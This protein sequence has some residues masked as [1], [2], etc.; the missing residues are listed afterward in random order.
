METRI[1][2]STYD[3][4]MIQDVPR[5]LL[6]PGSVWSMTDF[7]PDIDGAPIQKRGGWQAGG[8]FSG[9][10][11]LNAIAYSPFAGGDIYCAIDDRGHLWRSPTETFEAAVLAKSPSMYWRLGSGVG[12]TTATDSSG[13]G[14][15]GACTAVT[16]GQTGAVTG[17]PD[18]AALFGATSRVQAGTYVPFVSGS[19]RTFMG[20]FKRT[21]TA[22]RDALFSGA[23][24]SPTDDH[25]GAELF[26]NAGGSDV[27]FVAK[28][29]TA[30]GTWTAAWPL[31]GVYVFWTLTYDDTSRVAELFINGVSKGTK[32]LAS[33]YNPSPPSSPYLFTLGYNGDDSHT[34]G[35][36]DEIAVFEAILSAAEITTIYGASTV[37]VDEGAAVLTKQRPIFLND[38]LIVLPDGDTYTIP[39][40]F[41][42]ATISTLSLTGLTSVIPTYGV[43]YKSRL[44]I[45]DS[46]TLYFS[47]IL[48]PENYDVDSFVKATHPITGLAA[49]SNM[50]AIF[51][52]GHV[53]RLRGTTP[54]ST[55]TDGDMTLEP[56]FSEGCIDARS[57]VVYQDMMIWA[58]KN[59]VHISDGAAT[60]VNLINVGGIRDYWHALMEAY[61]PNWTLAG[62]IFK[63]RY[64]LAVTDG[65][66]NPGIAF[67]C[68]LAKKTWSLLNNIPAAMFS[69]IQGATSDLL[70][71]V[72][73]A[74]YIGSC[75]PMF[76][77]LSGSADGN[78]IP[79]EPI[80]ELA[81]FRNGTGSSRW[82]ELFLGLDFNSDSG[83]IQVF[84]TTRP[85]DTDYPVPMSSDPAIPI[86]ISGTDGYERV[87]IPIRAAANGLGIKIVQAGES[88]QTALFDLEAVTRVRE[89]R[90]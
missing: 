53:E 46:D 45:A 90:Y 73:N 79:V 24:S 51:S 5:H 43:G 58:N 28:R 48:D 50:I 4:G 81:F 30:A 38:T 10:T 44:V 61:S 1:L 49:L 82:R 78:G 77:P 65:T 18:T 60:P 15:T 17:D 19:K 41:D 9:A 86:Q 71:A 83:Q 72:S 12:A 63:G 16:F 21:S 87:R 13:H 2:Q 39:K 33:A 3:R 54:P 27:S 52:S 34:T 88:T 35:T 85:D 11:T 69:E 6:P 42:G 67:M 36:L 56:A 80:L 8:A 32:T 57:I 68:D 14:R 84:Y 22:N 75:A 64:V 7:I 55:L 26:I 59:G 66:G 31:T 37:W 25:L 40:K 89:G 74:N 70:M 47:D 20:W 23:N 62:G 29:G 76:D